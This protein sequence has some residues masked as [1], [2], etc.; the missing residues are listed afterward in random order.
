MPI[1]LSDTT[2]W[3]RFCYLSQVSQRRVVSSPILDTGHKSLIINKV[4]SS[5]SVHYEI[6]GNAVHYGAQNGI[7][8]FFMGIFT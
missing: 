5:L 8:P 6:R 4:F 2:L 3:S 1:L 7:Y